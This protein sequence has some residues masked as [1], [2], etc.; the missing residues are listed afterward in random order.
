MEVQKSYKRI[1]ETTGLIGLVQ[2]FHIL[3]SLISTK[4][5]AMFLGPQGIGL[6]G[7]YKN[8]F[9]MASK[10]SLLGIDQGGV[11]QIAK[12]SDNHLRVAKTVD[13]IRYTMVLLSLFFTISTFIFSEQ[14]SVSVFGTREYSS[15]V[16]VVAFAILFFGVASFYRTVLNGFRLIR[17]LAVSQLLSSFLGAIIAV[18][19]VMVFG[20]KG[21][22]F[23]VVAIPIISALVMGWFVKRLRI[24][25]MSPTF[26]E[27]KQELVRLLRIGLAFGFS[28]GVATIL[29]LLSRVYITRAFGIETVGIYQ[30]SWTISSIYVGTIL[31]A[32][33]VDLL[34]RLM[35][36]ADNNIEISKM[37]NEQMEL[38]MLVASVGVVSIL[39][40]SPI[41]LGL[42]Y[43]NDFLVGTDIIRWQVLGVSLRVLGFP[44]AYGIMAKG[45][46]LVY[47]VTQV[48]L[49]G[50]DY[51]FLILFVESF[52]FAGLGVNYPVAYVF[53]FVISTAVCRS[54]I[55]FRFS[56]FLKRIMIISYFFIL[57]AFF[58]SLFL[59]KYISYIF[60][61]IL[62]VGQLFWVNYEIKY[63]MG[64][65]VLT[66][67]SGRFLKKKL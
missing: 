34:P 16:Q 26:Y 48:I 46:S 25:K 50:G 7:L 28:G 36:V 3:F 63:K 57:C 42:F 4:F 66:I 45:K 58:L 14:I 47:V 30:A 44:F 5:L 62:I 40:F 61:I 35:K 53:Y 38:G 51:V 56:R 29:T 49:W 17:E 19:A 59:P 60:G 32:M 18:V 10:I 12:Y 27:G 13:V 52:G 2:V 39:V 1:L 41:V 11:R 37:I 15:G 43:S 20:F 55:D 64:L 21:I 9:E 67:L 23:Y 6:L 31:S 22:A 8:F 54:L 33:G 24:S 65:N